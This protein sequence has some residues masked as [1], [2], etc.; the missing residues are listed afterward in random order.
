[1]IGTHTAV[2]P[3]NAAPPADE[4][5]PSTGFES[6]LKQNLPSYI[7]KVICWSAALAEM[8]V[9]LA[10]HNPQ[11]WLSKQILYCLVFSENPPNIRLTIAF[12]LSTCSIVLGSYIRWS[13]Y[14]AL[15][16]LFTF[17]MA[18][19][20]NHRLV[21]EGPYRWARH[22]GY[23]GILLVISGL[24]C[25]HITPGSWAIECDVFDT[26]AGKLVALINL[27]LMLTV[28]VGLISRMFKE[29]EM[30]KGAFGKE[31]EEWARRVPYMLFPGV[32]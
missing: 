1:M 2:T 25:W 10:S 32:Y 8:L 20:R 27:G 16:R 31:W 28:A 24:T 21:T 14:R 19:R 23:T 5:M 9:I 29:D 17:Q 18:L 15:G 6:L 4:N 22:P 26:T 11:L 7:V 3:P 12:S 13:C 30:L